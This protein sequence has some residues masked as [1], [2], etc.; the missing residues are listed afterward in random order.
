[1][2]ALDLGF[3][4]PSRRTAL[5]GR[6]AQLG[7]PQAVA[8]ASLAAITL[9]ALLAPWLAPHSTTIPSTA[10]FVHPSSQA[11]FGSDEVGRDVFSRVLVGIRSSWFSALAVI[12]SGVLIGGSVGLIAG[13]SGGWLDGLLMRLTDLF[14]AIPGPILAIAVVAALGPSLFHTLIAVA[15]V[16]WPLYARVVRAQVRSL[17]KRPHIDAARLAGVGRVRLAFRHI[18]PGTISVTLVAASLDVGSLILTLAALSF[19]GL[20]EPAPA[21]E[22]GAMAARGLPDLLTA[23]WIPVFPA[24]AVFGLSFI[25]NLSGDS[26]RDLVRDDG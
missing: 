20:G 8:L 19:L 12:A 25:A 26:L 10:P 7:R 13:M 17:I 24:L 2:S 21:P 16:W 9:I 18:L 11:W 6:I 3:S 23:W 1:M 14:L 4:P 22:L 15:I 5:Q